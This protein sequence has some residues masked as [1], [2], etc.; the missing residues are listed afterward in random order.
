MNSFRLGLAAAGFLLAVLS[1]AI[2]NHQLGWAAIALL[3]GSLILRLMWRKRDN[4]KSDGGG[5]L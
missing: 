3:T 2:D 4:E 1:V 5:G